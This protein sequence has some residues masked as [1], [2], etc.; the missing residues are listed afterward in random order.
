MVRFGATMPTPFSIIH[1]GRRIDVVPESLWTA[2]RV[3]LL[4]DGETVAETKANGP[5]TVLEGGGVK[6]RA[7]MPL[8]GG[9]VKRAELV[10]ADGT[11]LR[12]EP[13]A[14]SR[15]A[16]AHRF[17]REHPGLYA[18]RHVAK[19]IGQA[20]VAVLGLTLA[21]NLLPGIPLPQVDLP[22]LDLPSLPLRRPDLPD[23]ELP[24]WVRA[25]LE[26]KK[27]WLPVLIGIALAVREWRRR[28]R[29]PANRAVQA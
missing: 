11:T 13:A 17:E 21:L 15:A 14:G 26:A 9:S 29:P 10:L 16:R 20:L 3:R 27:Y 1:E 19:G 7:V 6:V 23:L 24:G 12:L 25:V 5:K 18:A 8:W 28:H 22:E 2:D 4:V